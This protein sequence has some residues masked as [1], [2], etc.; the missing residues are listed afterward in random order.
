MTFITEIEKCTLK[1]I[2]KHKRLQ[3][4]K[5]I[6]SKKAYKLLFQVYRMIFSS[7]SHDFF[8]RKKTPSI[9]L[10]PFKTLKILFGPIC[11]LV[12]KTYS[13]K[14]F[15]MNL[16]NQLIILLDRSWDTKYIRTKRCEKREK[17]GLSQK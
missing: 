14:L 9:H 5:V 11:Y 3:K 12:N 8:D 10:P 17:T 6:L 13:A 16:F 2:W 7:V 1:F 15:G 4:A